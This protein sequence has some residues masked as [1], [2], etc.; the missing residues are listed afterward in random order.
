MRKHGEATKASIAWLLSFVSL[1]SLRGFHW[2]PSLYLAIALRL[3]PRLY[4]ALPLGPR[5][6]WL[7]PLLA[8]MPRDAPPGRMRPLVI[9]CRV[10]QRN[11]EHTAAMPAATARRLLPLYVASCCSYWRGALATVVATSRDPPPG[12]ASGISVSGHSR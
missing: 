8:A 3:M 10:E 6:L 9:T 7:W 5:G 2:L 12:A 1:Y 4:A 11:S